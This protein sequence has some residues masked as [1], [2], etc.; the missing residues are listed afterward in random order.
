MVSLVRYCPEPNCSAMLPDGANSCHKC[1]CPIHKSSTTKATNNAPST[2]SSAN[3]IVASIVGNGASEQRSAKSASAITGMPPIGKTRC[4]EPECNTIIPSDAKNCPAC[5]CPANSNSAFDPPGSTRDVVICSEPECRTIV[6]TGRRECPKCGC[7]VRKTTDTVKAQLVTNAVPPKVPSK[8]SGVHKMGSQSEDIGLLLLTEVKSAAQTLS[9]LERH[10]DRIGAE[11]VKSVREVLADTNRRI[12]RKEFYVVVVGEKKVGKSTFLNALLGRALL[13]TA[14]RE[15][16]GSVTFLRQGPEIDFTA[17]YENNTIET[18]ANVFRDRRQQFARSMKRAE[19][20]LK[21]S[22]TAQ[23]DMPLEL[24]SLRKCLAASSSELESLR[25]EQASTDTKYTQLC[26]DLE[27]K[28]AELNA[29]ESANKQTGKAIPYIFR[30]PATKLNLI[31]LVGQQ[32]QAKSAKP[33]W[34]AHIE[35]CNQCTEQKKELKRFRKIV[36]D[37]HIQLKAI[38]DRV[39]KSQRESSILQFQIGTSERKLAGLPTRIAIRQ[40]RL[41]KMVS[42]LDAYETKRSEAFATAIKQY[43]DQDKKGRQIRRLDIQIPSQHLPPDV[44]VIDTPGV[45]TDNDQ[46]RKRAWETIRREA[47][48]C[49]VL[50]DIQQSVSQSTCEFV[51]EVKNYLPHLILVL[52]K[53]DRALESVVL[54]GGAEA[55]VEEAR[56]IGESRFAQTVG[57][58]PGDIISFAMSA[59]QALKGDDAVASARF[60]RDLKTITSLLRNERALIV[61]TRC[62]KTIVTCQAQVSSVQS[63][64]ERAYVKTIAELESNR[65]PD[66]IAFCRKQLREVDSEIEDLAE[67]IVSSGSEMIFKVYGAVSGNYCAE[68]NKCQSGE[69]LKEYLRLVQNSL[70]GHLQKV[71]RAIQTDLGKPVAAAVRELEE[72]L[73]RSLKERYHIVRNI[74]GASGQMIASSSLGIK[75]AAPNIDINLSTVVQDFQNMKVGG[76]A[77]GAIA[78]GLIGSAIPGLGTVVG[79]IVGGLAG[80]LFGPRFDEVK[81]DC[82]QRFYNLMR[83]LAENASRDLVNKQSTIERE[84]RHSIEEGL[85][86]AVRQYSTWIEKL[87]SSEQ[88]RIASE[89]QLLNHLVALKDRMVQH[90]MRLE[91]L[92][93]SAQKQSRGMVK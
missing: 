69:Q 62:A 13:S 37:V 75:T 67:L 28:E 45:N 64:A 14:V 71:N 6:P 61:A 21:Q 22:R 20:Q 91:S 53:L 43:T 12:A 85:K 38:S 89:K 42:G 68:I 78:G 52:T 88:N 15:C 93:E 18:F 84:I 86:K 16:T 50:S 73:L 27:L 63:K 30:R 48:G 49:I 76:I 2:T 19:S 58:D 4:R 72:P 56:Q 33:E 25:K 39:L 83:E 46:N 40:K 7:P 65:I 24:D 10:E 17:T 31:R 55:E 77:G 51:R 11:L 70:G 60:A 8:V 1:G 66:P 41:D 26:H 90:Q 81:N 5:G 80:L 9:E 34:L 47:D 74:S 79:G 3:P 23:M 32:F 35:K 29:F 44:I 87:I 92:I 82:I 54:D 36:Q 59:E 57:R